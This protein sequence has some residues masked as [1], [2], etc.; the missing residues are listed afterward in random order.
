VEVELD[1]PVG[2]AV[3]QNVPGRS[4]DRLEVEVGP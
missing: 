3:P 2:D 4:P 1:S